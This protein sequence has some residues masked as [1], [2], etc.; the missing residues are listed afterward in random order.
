MLGERSL[1]RA[2]TTPPALGDPQAKNAVERDADGFANFGAT[3]R[4]ERRGKMLFPKVR[5]LLL[6][7]TRPLSARVVAV[8]LLPVGH[9]DRV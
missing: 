2:R 6:L 3:Q 9:A 4:P 1:K 5:D 8:G 7:R